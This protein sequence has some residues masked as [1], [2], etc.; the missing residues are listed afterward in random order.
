M[1]LVVWGTEYSQIHIYLPVP[2]TGAATST[3]AFSCLVLLQKPFSLLLYNIGLLRTALD[4]LSS[5]NFHDTITKI[6]Q[7]ADAVPRKSTVAWLAANNSTHY[8]PAVYVK[9]VKSDLTYTA[10]AEL[11]ARTTERYFLRNYVK[12][13]RQNGRY[14]H[15]VRLET[16]HYTF[17]CYYPSH[18]K[19]ILSVSV[20]QCIHCLSALLGLQ[21]ARQQSGRQRNSISRTRLS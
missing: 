15:Y 3:H 17:Y 1:L 10:L 21:L 19:C 4:N 14:A 5:N 8:W 12:L 16:G 11:T 7:S 6:L 13:L 2:P 20:M 18:M 9:S